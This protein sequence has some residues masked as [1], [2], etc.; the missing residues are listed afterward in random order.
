MKNFL[1]ASHESTSLLAAV[2]QLCS[3][4]NFASYRS[5][6]DLAAIAVYRRPLFRQSGVMN[7]DPAHGRGEQQVRGQRSADKKR[8]HGAGN[9]CD[10]FIE[11]VV[12]MA[13]VI[14]TIE[15]KVR[16]L[17]LKIV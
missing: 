7:H 14:L 9:A 15:G 2:I 4:R 11:P 8:F 13:G 17:T 10:V 3:D 5:E 1:E 12:W 16:N 6:M